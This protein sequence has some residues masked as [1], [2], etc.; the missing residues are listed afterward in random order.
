MS[1]SEL[2]SAIPVL[3]VGD[4]QQSLGFY[5]KRL[6]F[7]TAF[8]YGP[9]AGVRRGPIE[10]HL[11]AEEAPAVSCRVAVRG[12]D[13]L[14]EEMQKQDVI[15]PD[16]PLQTQPWGMRQFSVLDPSGNRIT[17]A[18]PA[19]AAE[20]RAAPRRLFMITFTHVEGVRDKLKAEDVPKFIRSHQDW[21]REVRE[22]PNS[23]LVY[24]DNVQNA[25]T[26]RRD[27]DGE[28]EV[29][30]GPFTQGPE[31]AGGFYIIE[32][33]SV[34]EAVELAKRH[35]W[36]PGSNEVREIVTPPGTAAWIGTRTP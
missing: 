20:Q 4:L 10:I 3:P 29:L 14:Y 11:S 22:Q 24:V 31:A 32:A 34:D 36:L 27:D 1:D 21:E 25:R 33:D 35:R 28:I 9:Y 12:V 15:H 5:A 19:D 17:F 16:E 30:D 23:S 13:V 26:V 7:D 18:E 8:E 2:S 6:G